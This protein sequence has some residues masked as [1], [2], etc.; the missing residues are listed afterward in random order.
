M[1]SREDEMTGKR[2]LNGNLGGFRITYFADHDLV[3]IVAKDGA[4]SARKRQS[5]LLVHRNLDDSAKQ[6]LYRIFDGYD[7][8]FSGMNFR[9]RR[10]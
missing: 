9:Q 5:L 2:R 10:I 4:Q 6:I 1:D 3:R 8:F 7:L